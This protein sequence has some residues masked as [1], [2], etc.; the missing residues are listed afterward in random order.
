MTRFK[1]LLYN[2]LLLLLFSPLKIF[3]NELFSFSRYSSK[4][5]LSCNY[6]HDIVQ[7]KNGFLWIATEY[8]LNRF[9]GVHF[10]SYFVEECPSLCRNQVLHLY[11]TPDGR[12]LAAGN[13]GVII[14]YD[15]KSDSFVDLI[16]DDFFTTYFK[17]ITNFHLDNKG[18]LWATTTNGVYFYNDTIGK[19]DKHPYLTDSTSDIFISAMKS[20]GF[21][22]YL[23]GT[24]TGI[25]VF[26]EKGYHF[27]KYDDLL[28]T[29]KLISNIVEIEKNKFLVSSFVGGLWVFSENED[30]SIEKAQMLDIPFINVSSVLKDSKG[31]FWFGA[32]G[33]GLWRATYDG[34][35][36]FEKIEPKNIK[37]E[38]LMK[39]HCLYEDSNGDVWIGTQ[40]AGL[41]RYRSI[42][43]SG[44]IHSSDVGF[45]MVDGTSFA[46]DE[47]GNI[48]VAADGHGVFLLA[49]DLSL[50]DNFTIEDGLSSNNVLSVKKG[51]DGDFWIASWGGELCKLNT[52]TKKIRKVPFSSIGIPFITCKTV[53]P[54][55]NG[56]V[57]VAMSGDGV[58]SMNKTGEWSRKWLKDDGSFK[59]PDIWIED[60]TESKQGVR[61]IVTA[62]SVWRCDENGEKS[63]FP[64]VDL[65]QMH[66]PLLMLQGACD[67]EGNLY[68]VSSQGILRFEADGS[69]YAKLDYLPDGQYSSIVKDENGVFWTGG[70][71]GVLSF[72][73]RKKVFSKI[74]LDD[75]FR[76]RNYFTCR[77][78]FID[79]SGRIYFGST[80][81][82]VMIDPKRLNVSDTVDYLQFSQLYMQGS[83]QSSLP[84]CLVDV[85]KLE[86]NYDETN[87]TVAVDVIDFSGLNDVELFYRLKDLDKEWIDLQGKREIKISHIPSGSYVLEVKA[88]KRSAIDSKI[89]TLPVV[90]SPPWWNTWWF[91]SLIALSVAFVTFSVISYRFRRIK[92][93]KDLLSKMVTE[94]TR[95]LDESNHLLEQ[96]QLLIEQRNKDLEQALQEKDRL[97]SVIAH[98]LKNPMFAIV[99]ALDSVL[100]NHSSLENTWKTLK[101][102][103]LSAFNL[104]SAMVKLLEWARGKQT[105]VVCHVEDASVRKMVQEVVSLLNGL[106]KEKK[107][108]VSTSFNVSHC[109]LMDSRMIGT[110][111]RN[112][113]S[114]AVKFTP[115]EGSVEIEVLEESG[116][117]TMKVT[118]T[119]VGM[120]EEQLVS[121]RNNENVISTMGTKMEKGTGLGFKMA[122]D[123]VEKSGGVLLVDSKKNE[124]TVITIKLPVALTDDVDDLE[125]QQQEEL[126][127]QFEY[128]AELLQGN[129]VMIVDDDPLILLHLRTMLEP[130]FQV[131]EANNG[132]EGL[133]VAKRELPDLI[134]SDVEMPKMDGIRMYES[135]KSDPSTAYI[136]LLFLSARNAESDR[137]LGLYKGAIDYI[138][139][140][141]Y[142]KEL[143]IKL[144]NILLL[145]RERQQRVLREN[146]EHLDEKTTEKELN[147]LLRALLKLVEERYSDSNFSADDMSTA[148]AMSKSTFSRKLK[149]ITDKTPTEILTEYRLHKAQDL[150]KQGN[151]SVTEIAYSVGFNDPLYFSKK[152]KSY[153][154]I[155]PSMEK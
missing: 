83:G 34:T 87:F 42:G 76:S 110:A 109:A 50:L 91:Y 22:R 85:P 5:G 47:E 100:K 63:V 145:R 88:K 2:L 46:Q 27:K 82:F 15:E 130:Y 116:Y 93:Q 40:N 78:S 38:E 115:E 133:A 138:S 32:A 119:G 58:Y 117:I 7:D 134:L 90:V 126:S 86:L 95:E 53:Y 11:V 84:Q 153:F 17:G 61:W 71:N 41:L 48:L 79:G 128:N 8:G 106:F 33:S 6:V 1:L 55:S 52:K 99:G 121:I 19:F 3:A 103:Y 66:R 108:K 72:D 74:L 57:W 65:Q 31:R 140:P 101:D 120:T 144:N 131:V 12:F 92:E 124:G 98:D 112:V 118:D 155:S 4:D 56:E 152:Y 23:C 94:R 96:K 122:K 44:T 64:D 102:I 60:I 147:P 141:F 97:L 21:G 10:R 89:V 35:F 62:R 30:G 9:D 77:A 123:F 132:E 29:G 54:F 105:D 45:P 80:E 18:I 68:V 39:I 13:N 146:Y 49:P 137:L 148:L 43:S 135:L 107:I 113:L 75:R 150:L 70:S 149:S 59:V 111:L 127:G 25:S 104:Q 142:D 151:M 28:S 36:H 154:G 81:G 125:K 20:D 37:S 114:N 136:P 24:Y 73:D 51:L 143:L 67:E 26:D 139:K 129:T 16:P 14:S 69:A